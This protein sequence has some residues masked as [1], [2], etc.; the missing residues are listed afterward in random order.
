MPRFRIGWRDRL[1]HHPR[2]SSTNIRLGLTKIRT[3]WSFLQIIYF[4]QLCMKH[5]LQRKS[6][7]CFP[8][9]GIV[10]AQ[11]QFP[12]SCVCERFIYSQDRSTY[13]LQQNR[14]I[15]RGNILYKSLTNAWMWKLGLWPRKSFSGNKC[16]Q[17]SVLV[18]CSAGQ[19]TAGAWHFRRNN[20]I[21]VTGMEKQSLG[22]PPRI[23]KIMYQ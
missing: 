18:P 6:H 15:D 13:F 8:F 23:P 4:L 21:E 10:R 20:Y 1:V 16:F 14:Q 5:T 19:V 9:L 2:F 12:H 7:L 11:S 17:F 3:A 22:S